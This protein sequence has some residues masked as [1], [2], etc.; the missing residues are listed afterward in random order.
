MHVNRFA[1]LK[2]Y[3][4]PGHHDM[5]MLRM[6][7]RE[8]GPA[9]TTWLGVSQI[10]PGGRVDLSGSPDE[11]FYVVLEGELTVETETGSALLGVW[12]SCR[13]APNEKRALRNQTN[14]TVVVL[15]AMPLPKASS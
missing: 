11:K 7:G 4:A 3:E 9:D 15:I 6:Q 5:R 12:D 8:A 14:R 1:D 2:P 10:L 13:I